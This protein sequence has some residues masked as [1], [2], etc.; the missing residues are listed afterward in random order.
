M[1]PVVRSIE[2]PPEAVWSLLS[3]LERWGEILPT[4]DRVARL[5]GTGPVGVG[6]RFK[7][8]QPGLVPAV[9]DV[10][11]WRPGQGFRWAARLPGLRSVAT[12]EVRA[13]APGR[14]ELT[15]DLS[16]SGVLAPLIR[17]LL[18]AKAQRM[19]EQEA[20]TFAALAAAG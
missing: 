20:A 10:T 13:I 9:Y 2:A 7:V 16:W 17:V 14:T 11:D 1:S 4:V 3:D 8:W 18:A 6:S 5:D 15:L 12:H 19:V